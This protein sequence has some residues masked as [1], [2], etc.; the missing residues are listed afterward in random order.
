MIP[1]SSDSK[2]L[3]KPEQSEPATQKPKVNFLYQNKPSPQISQIPQQKTFQQPI[4]IS[5]PVQTF[6]IPDAKYMI[7]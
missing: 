7:Q 2:K 1:S 6:Q 5:K 4:N 3:S